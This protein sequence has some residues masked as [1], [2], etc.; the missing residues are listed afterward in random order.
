MDSLGFAVLRLPPHLAYSRARANA[1]Y[2]TLRPPGDSL[3]Y[4]F[5]NTKI[6]F[7]SDHARENKDACRICDEV[8]LPFFRDMCEYALRTCRAV[9]ALDGRGHQDRVELTVRALSGT[10]VVLETGA[11]TKSTQMWHIDNA[12]LTLSVP[13]LGPSTEVLPNVHAYADLPRGEDQT[14]VHIV[15]GLALCMTGAHRTLHNVPT[16]HRAPPTRERR[17]TAL[18]FY[19]LN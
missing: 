12:Y 18:A 4:Y 13:L 9:A 5:D 19:Y 2:Q 7:A 3:C 14:P 8:D 11:I 10:P 1:L 15:P 17:L 16:M 6:L